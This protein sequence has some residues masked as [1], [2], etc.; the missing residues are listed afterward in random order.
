M[1]IEEF[2]LS[3]KARQ[4]VEQYAYDT[5]NYTV[6]DIVDL[7][8]ALGF[9]VG[10][11]G[12]NA[13]RQ[14][15]L[16]E[17]PT[18]SNGSSGKNVLGKLAELLQ[19]NGIDVDDIGRVDSVKVWQGYF[20]DADGNAQTVDMSGITLHPKWAEGPEWPV[21]QR[22][23]VLDIPFRRNIRIVERNG[24]WLRA[25]VLPDIQIGFYRDSMG[26][27]HPTH[28]ENAL[29]IVLQVIA[30][31]QPDLIIMVG[32]N[33]DFPELSKYRLHPT[34]Q[35]TTQASIDKAGAL[36]AHLRDLAPHAEIIWLA[37]NHEERLSNYVIDNARAAY[38]LKQ[39]NTPSSWPALS[40]PHLCRFD[41][42][43]ITYLPG[44]PANEYWVNDRLRVIHGDK[45][46]SSGSTA[47]RYL[48]SE[49]VS[50]IY[51]H[52][53]RQEKE[54]KT[55]GTRNGPR[56]IMAASP[57]C[58]CR[59]DGA[60]PGTRTGTDLDGIPL[61]RY[62]NWQQGIGVVT[63]KPGDQEFVYEDALIFSG[64]MVF[65]DKEYRA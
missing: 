55:R 18:T 7:L 43:G 38:G 52:I 36:L 42:Y 16:G 35:L 6:A 54:F 5:E 8:G 41:D 9:N 39:A 59:I 31:L 20:K 26:N 57:G 22:A 23:P 33:L 24:Q 27:L 11:H 45:V 47:S 40:V 60:V 58:L 30:D 51:G 65:R 2:P 48:D 50:T 10:W 37:G 62:E 12:A 61:V 56:T 44:Y 21:I 1:K 4:Q 17:R 49:R 46:N 13:Y 14:R 34:F 29:A 19:R 32:D 53:H 28:D 3:A 64:Y 15:L 63:F 25:I